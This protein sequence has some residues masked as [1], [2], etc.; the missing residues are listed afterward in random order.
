MFRQ[1]ISY[2]WA[3]GL[4]EDDREGFRRALASLRKIPEL[5]MVT[6]GDD[7]GHFPDNHDFVAVMDF[8]N[9]EA[10]RRYVEASEHQ[11]FVRDHALQAHR[12]R[13]VVQ[14]DWAVGAA[15]SIHH[16]KVPVSDVATSRDWYGRAFSLEVTQE[17]RDGDHLSGVGMFHPETG[18]GVALRHDPVRAGALSGF[19][20]VA[21]TVATPD[22]L[23][24]ML[25]RLREQGVAFG[26][27]MP[28][29][30]GVVVD[31]PDPDGII[32]RLFTLTS[33]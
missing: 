3:D 16:V 23:D 27:P 19:D 8:P 9:F 25:D 22:D 21:L 28:G 17:F 11:A 2:R 6:F 24:L 13:V 1:V 33:A 32:I 12:E 18:T 10:A 31:V 29:R 20:V 4:S 7:A 26:E 14:H 30:A 5:H 15:T